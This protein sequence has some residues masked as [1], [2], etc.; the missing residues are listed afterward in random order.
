MKSL[1][2]PIPSFS[3]ILKASQAPILSIMI[4]MICNG[5]FLTYISV[6]LEL[7]KVSTWDIGLVHSA[8]YLGLLIG[9]TRIEPLIARIGHIRTYATFASMLTATILAQGFWIHPYYWLIL[10]FFAG[11]SL[12]GLY[13]VIESWLL[14]NSPHEK[15]GKMLSVYMVALYATQSLSQFIIDWIPLLGLIPYLVASIFCVLSLIPLTVT[16][17]CPPNIPDSAHVP[18]LS[19]FKASPFGFSGCLIS[20]FMISAIYSL[21]PNFSQEVGL[22]IALFTSSTIAGGFLLQWPIGHLSD[23]FDRSRVLL[24]LSIATIFPCVILALFHSQS[25]LPYFLGFLIGGFSFA[26]YPVSISQ[27]CDRTDSGEITRTAGVLLL[28]YGMG[29]VIG[30]MAL[31]GAMQAISPLSLFYG[32]ALL[33][34]ILS[35]IG[36][37]SSIARK[38]VPMEEQ[39]DY[40]AL[41]RTTPI[42][43][44]L[45][46]RSSEEE[47][48]E[49]EES[50]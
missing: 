9:S 42:V 7:E 8:F 40:V 19:L 12:A 10:R 30:P 24:S 38:R 6:R 39:S 21:A 14:V 37:Y 27:V 29:S 44:E 23:I 18:L 43:Y 26:I 28:A 50:L 36:L 5:F 34:T 31:S 4:L 49:E 25:Y 45:D 32:L 2:E 46:P 35:G 1:R 20:G 3:Y 48:E 33:A 16:Y 13:I 15:R 22:N 41:P 17:T 47:E 11:I